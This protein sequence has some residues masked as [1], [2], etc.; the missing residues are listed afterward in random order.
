MSYSA[1]DH[2]A[3]SRV[4]DNSDNTIQP[5]QLETTNL[6]GR[7]VRLGSVIDDI[8]SAHDYPD[9]VSHIM[10]ETLLLTALLSSMLKYDGIFTL[11]TQG[12]GPISRLVADMT[13]D[14][15]LRG[16]AAFDED[17]IKQATVQIAA[18]KKNES[19]QNQLAQLL[20][21]GYIALPSIR[22]N[23]RIDIRES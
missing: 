14:G 19:A 20:G 15:D 3:G 9:V 18:L 21:K 16:C 12:D 1:Q 6:R 22:G 2:G 13:T 8:L 7:I 5:F 23:I 17:R 11:Q 4:F 10:G